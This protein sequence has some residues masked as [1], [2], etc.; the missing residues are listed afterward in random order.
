EAAQLYLADIAALQ[1]D[2]AA[3]LAGYRGLVDSSVGITARVRA[4]GLLLERGNRPEALSL[5]DDYVTEHPESS[6][7]MTLTK[8]Q[9]LSQ[10]GEADA[11]LALLDAALERHPQHP[12][13]E[14]QRAVLF[15]RNGQVR[16][17]ITLLE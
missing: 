2:G 15:E 17:S 14:Y 11:G 6:F 8:A 7:E 12:T 1:G 5:L 3:A 4:A 9:L 10:H 13:I 16:E